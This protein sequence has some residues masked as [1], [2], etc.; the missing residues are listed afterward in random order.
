[1]I[2][3]QRALAALVDS[4]VRF[5]LVRRLVMALRPHR[6]YPRGAP[7]GLPFIW[8]E[9]T[10]EMGLNFTL[11]TAVGDIDVLGEIAG[12]GGFHQLEPHA[13]PIT[14][15]GRTC[16]CLGLEKLIAT[17]RAA[18]RPKDFEVIAELELI[19]AERRRA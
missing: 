1:M 6:P 8:D 5:I 13:E 11:E 4:S 7:P 15:Y 9:K 18:G 3:F 17:K 10:V 2:D 19:L 14:L 16:L 12:G